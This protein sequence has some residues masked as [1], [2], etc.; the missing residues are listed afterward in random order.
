MLFGRRGSSGVCGSV[1]GIEFEIVLVLGGGG[2]GGG[3]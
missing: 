3:V 1:L 2:G